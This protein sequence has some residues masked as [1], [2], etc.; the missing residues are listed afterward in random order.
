MTGLPFWVEVEDD[1]EWKTSLNPN[2]G[3]GNRDICSI[4]IFFSRLTSW[5]VKVRFL[6]CV[7]SPPGRGG[8][9]VRR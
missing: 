9:R 7:I 5:L 3:V 1:N 2:P 8:E 6:G 4:Y